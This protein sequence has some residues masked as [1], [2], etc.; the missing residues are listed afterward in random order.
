[1]A[2]LPANGHPDGLDGLEASAVF[3]HMPAEQ[4]GVP[5]VDGPLDARAFFPG[6]QSLLS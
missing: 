5:C 4:L 6:W 1:M 2:K 3:G